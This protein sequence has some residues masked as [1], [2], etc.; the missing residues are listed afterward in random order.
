MPVSSTASDV[1][2]FLQDG[3]ISEAGL[4]Q[5]TVE[6]VEQLKLV[7]A[8]AREQHRLYPKAAEHKN[9]RKVDWEERARTYLF[10][11]KRA[12]PLADV[13][14][15]K[16][17]LVE[18]GFTSPTAQCLHQAL[19]RAD[20]RKAV[21][22]VLRRVKASR[23]GINMLDI[24]VCGAVA[25]YG[26]VLGGKLVSMLMCSPQVAAA[27]EHRYQGASSVIASAMAGRPVRRSPELVLL[28]TTSLYGVGSSQ[29][30]RIRLP[31]GEVGGGPEGG[32]PL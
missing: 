27:Y 25:P 15:A 1:A 11:S 17:K 12:V 30:N 13:L 5:P 7:A 14:G 9:G 21:K 29:Y 31:A 2:D 32:N 6:L 4:R 26:P 16:L 20:A 8:D 23:V 24:T 28:G 18:A 22:R 10:R 3:T 19:R